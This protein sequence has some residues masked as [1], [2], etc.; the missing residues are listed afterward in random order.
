MAQA[1]APRTHAGVLFTVAFL[2][3][4]G[5]GDSVKLVPAEGI[6][7]INGQPAANIAV[8]FLPDVTKGHTGPTSYGTTNAEGKFQ[9]K[10][11]DGREGAVPGTHMVVLADLEEE[12]PPQGQVA[13]KAP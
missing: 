4:S 10:T 11:Y 3:L 6:V 8:Q 13:K 2:T 5:C 12:R 9:L 1:F 7:K